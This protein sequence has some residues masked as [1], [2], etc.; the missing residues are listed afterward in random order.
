M[1]QPVHLLL[2]CLQERTGVLSEVTV[3]LG[4][5]ERTNILELWYTKPQSCVPTKCDIVDIA[6]SVETKTALGKA[7]DYMKRY[8]QIHVNEGHVIKALLSLE[9]IQSIL[10]EELK[11]SLHYATKARDMIVYLGSY[12]LPLIP[13]QLIRKA[14]VE[15]KNILIK[16]VENHFSIDWTNTVKQAFLMDSIPIYVAFDE[17]QHVIGFAGFDI[18]NGKKAYFGPMGVAKDNRIKGIGYA[19]L[20]H[21][22]RDMKE[23]GYDYAIIGG[24]GP[25]EFYEKACG[26]IIIPKAL[27]KMQC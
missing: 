19:L 23:V 3:A 26:A 6:L 18:Y 2:G 4:E 20:H 16:F 5:H 1:L 22:L 27:Y 9:S 24:A 14:S 11:Q 13:F 17:K 25:I 7:I 8:N 10:P 15:D 21:C 12:S